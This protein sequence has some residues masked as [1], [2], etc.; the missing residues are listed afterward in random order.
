MKSLGNQKGL[1]LIEIVVVTLII[2]SAMAVA[3]SS[4]NFGDGN[5]LRKTAQN[6]IKIV[7]YSYNN[8]NLTGNYYR[9]SFNFEDRKYF[10]EYSQDPFYIVKEG[11]EQEQIR[12]DNEEGNDDDDEE[13]TTTTAGGDFSEDE[14]DYLEIFELPSGII[15]SDVFVEHQLEKKEDGIAYLYFFPRGHTEFA[16]IHLSD[17]EEEKFL[18]LVINPLT[19]AVEVYDDYLENDDVME[20]LGMSS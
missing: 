9:I 6:I 16:I 19:A 20:E 15:F 1:T 4:L 12:I 11:D 2:A 17:D 7:K 8:A 18:T 5:K 13:S 3:A 14:S 10:V